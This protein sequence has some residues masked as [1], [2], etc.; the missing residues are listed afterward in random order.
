MPPYRV[1][2]VPAK[3]GPI[4]TGDGFAENVD[5]LFSIDSTT[6]YGSLLA[7]GRR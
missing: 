6:R 4:T 1:F 7:Q 5:H 3:Q 2:V